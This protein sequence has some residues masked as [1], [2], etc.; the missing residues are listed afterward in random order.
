MLLPA[1][2]DRVPTRRRVTRT[3]G[4]RV[5]SGVVPGAFRPTVSRFLPGAFSSA[6][7]AAGVVPAAPVSAPPPGPAPLPTSLTRQ[8]LLDDIGGR[9]A[10]LPG[11]F[12]P[13][14]EASAVTTGRGLTDQ[15][16]ADSAAAR[17]LSTTGDGSIFGIDWTGE[18]QQRRNMRQGT[19]ASSN[20]RGTYFSTARRRQDRFDG[21]R[22]VN[23]R[24]S[25]L[26]NLQASQ[27]QSL[28]DQQN[29]A[30]GLS[31]EQNTAQQDYDD[32]RA[33]QTAPVPTP[34]QPEVP[35]PGEAGSGRRVWTGNTRPNLG[36][37]WT[38]ARRGPSAKTRWVA[39][40]NGGQ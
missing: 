34:P 25:I 5:A 29:A 2:P 9:I 14:R 23:T 12:N 22:V 27:T 15:G 20:S 35:G 16:L 1:R 36:P 28:R 8:A 40:F 11:I 3:T 19:A 10:A 38:V 32:W 4:S 37:G 26:R 39:T 6:A 13:A 17:A 24:D 31:G 33:Q 7:P 18:G 21:E 30:Q